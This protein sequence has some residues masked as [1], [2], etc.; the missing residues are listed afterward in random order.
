TGED[1]PRIDATC[2]LA[3]GG[4]ELVGGRLARA[5][6]VAVEFVI[7]AFDDVVLAAAT[8]PPPQPTVAAPRPS[9]V[10][11]PSPPAAPP[12]PPAAPPIAFEAPAR[13]RMASPGSEPPGPPPSWADVARTSAE[14]P[15]VAEAAAPGEEEEPLRTGDVIDHPRFGR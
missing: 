1:G 14:R 2:A 13:G 15:P 11:P 4:G 5:R 3:R 7:D 6:V 12:S 9:V 10:A 8:S